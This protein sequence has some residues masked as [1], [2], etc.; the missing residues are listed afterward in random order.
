MC[1]ELYIYIMRME[2]IRLGLIRLKRKSE[3]V[4]TCT[5]SH[6]GLNVFLLNLEIVLKSMFCKYSS[7]SHNWR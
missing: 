1:V 3:V 5:N 7:L 2:Y 6:Y 4:V